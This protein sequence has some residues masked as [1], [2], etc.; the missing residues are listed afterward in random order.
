M[1]HPLDRDDLRSR[2]QD[3]IDAELDR[4]ESELA[5]VGPDVVDLTAPVR[6]LLR[7][8]KRLRAGFAYWGWR[9][10]GQD[11]HD[12]AVSLAASMELFQAAALIHDDVMDDSET[13]RGRPAMHR[14]LARSHADRAWH[15][16]PDR[17]GVAGAILAG[18][19]CLGWCDDL[20]A[21]SGLPPQALT[22]ARPV[23]ERMRGQLM[24]GQ[25]LDIVTSMRPWQRLDDD[26]RV[27]AA[28]QVIRYKSAKYSIEHPLLIGATAGGA[29]AT[30]LAALSRYGLALGEAFQLRDDVLGVFGDPDVTGKPAGDDLREGK[31]T[32]LIARAL[33][34]AD[35]V[36]TT[37]IDQWLGAPDLTGDEVGAFRELL[38]DTG[39]LDGVEADI[40][41][42]ADAARAALADAT[43]VSEPARTVLADLVDVTT[44]RA[45]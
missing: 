31:R 3:R 14:A 11:D 28:R 40:T 18:N 17:F 38:V 1:P 25:F 8:G 12:G 9:A 39:A 24:G 26:E 19:L 34:G 22:A 7:G 41:A 27:A 30:D 29:S 36:M 42:G 5:E 16:D 20:F 35:D 32:V 33:A 43:G 4:W 21:D 37:R 10:A 15:G 44:A 6:T 45:T 23:F 2:V 13:R